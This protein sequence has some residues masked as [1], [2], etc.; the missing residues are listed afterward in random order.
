VI[1]DRE[2]DDMDVEERLQALERRLTELRDTLDVLR[3]VAS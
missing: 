1:A 2:E 3:V